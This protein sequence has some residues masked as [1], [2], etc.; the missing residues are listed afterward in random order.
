MRL[1][2]PPRPARTASPAGADCPPGR[3]PWRAA[4]TAPGRGPALA[5]TRGFTLVEVMVALVILATMAG[6]AWQGV[7]MIVRSRA[8]ASD[9][10]ERLL[11]LQSVLAQWEVDLREIA[12]TQNVPGFGFDGATLRLTR[13]RDAGVQVVAWTLRDRT[14]TRWAGP[15]AVSGDALQEAWMHSHQLLPVEANQLTMLAG[16]DSWQ[17]YVYSKRSGSWSN[18]QSTGDLKSDDGAAA[19]AAAAAASGASSG[20]VLSAAASTRA[21][22]PDGVRLTLQFGPGSGGINGALV[23]DLQLVHP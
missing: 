1:T 18:G 12:D 19:A 13:R 15:V 4:G 20:A 5:R 16:V 22:L 17:V 14:L 10:V 9:R 6:M 21:A 3:R 2:A 23:R 8:A 7:D 11:R